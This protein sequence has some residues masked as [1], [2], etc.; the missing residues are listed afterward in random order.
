M[1]RNLRSRLD[2]LERRPPLPDLDDRPP[3]GFWDWLSGMP[4]GDDEEELLC[5]A[6]WERSLPPGFDPTRDPIEER[7]AELERQVESRP[8]ALCELLPFSSTG[9]RESEPA[10]PVNQLTDTPSRN[11]HAGS[12]G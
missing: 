11:G 3:A 7:L 4:L 9:E 1:N 12:Y 2:R 6:F 10:V 8:C 5:R